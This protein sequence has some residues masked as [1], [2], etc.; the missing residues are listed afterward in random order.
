MKNLSITIIYHANCLDGIT[1]AW[2]VRRNLRADLGDSV[3][4]RLHPAN[5]GDPAPDVTGQD[6]VCV[7]DFSYPREDLLRMREQCGGALQ[8]VDHHKTAEANCEGLDFCT[9]DMNQSGAGLAWRELCGTEPPMLVRYVEDRDL[10]RFD[11]PQCREI[12]A[13]LETLPKTLD[14]FEG[15]H[16]ALEENPGLCAQIGAAVL[17]AKTRHVERVCE[18]AA[19]FMLL[20]RRAQIAN[21]QHA[22][23][24]VGHALLAMNGRAEIAIVWRKD[25]KR[26]VYLY[27]L[28]SSDGGPDVSALAKE[29]GGGGHANAAGFESPL[30]P[31]MLPMG[32][33]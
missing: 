7:V 32:A 29:L 12:C 24:E 25:E 21:C 3:N 26:G 8:V 33:R 17:E 30:P 13:W 28:R 16:N 10:W 19:P 9:F 23:S 11:L 31:A 18:T 22:H 1:A 27:S 20:G 5:Y 6:G 4:L 2:V 14:A 15:A